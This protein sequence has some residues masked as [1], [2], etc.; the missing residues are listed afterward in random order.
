MKTKTYLAPCPHCGAIKRVT[1]STNDWWKTK[2]IF[3]SD[4]RIESDDWCERAFIHKCDECGKFF[5]LPNPKTLQVDETPCA[6]TQILPYQ[7]LQTAIEELAGDEMAEPRARLEYWWSYNAFHKSETE[8]PA[9]ENQ[10]YCD[11]MRW[12]VN[13]HTPRAKRFDHIVYELN[14]LLG[15]KD[16]CQQMIDNLTYEEFM[17][18]K[19]EVRKEKGIT[20][21][22]D[23]EL[24]KERYNTEIKELT[25][26]LTQPP[27]PFIKSDFR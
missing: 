23:E 1:F 24:F 14:R 4:S 6:P 8:I 5:L 12:L 11:N 17:R 15:R 2:Y 19:I 16:I 21:P 7:T 13:F 9:E 10:F 22:I 25:H 18:Q 3:W 27:R 20:S 26:A